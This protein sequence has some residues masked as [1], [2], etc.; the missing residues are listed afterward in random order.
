M[1]FEDLYISL[2]I[3]LKT[4]YPVNYVYLKMLLNENESYLVLVA[5]QIL[6]ISINNVC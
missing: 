3:K 5:R 2:F 1:K 6:L 4:V